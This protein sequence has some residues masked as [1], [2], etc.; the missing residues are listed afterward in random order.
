MTQY[1]NID[2]VFLDG[3]PEGLREVAWQAQPRTSSPAAR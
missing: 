1:G 2:V 3:A